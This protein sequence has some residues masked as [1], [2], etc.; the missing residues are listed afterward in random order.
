MLTAQRRH[1]PPCKRPMWDKGYTKCTCPV[2]IRGTLNRER[3]YGHLNSGPLGFARRGRLNN[4]RVRFGP[5]RTADPLPQQRKITR[6]LNP[7]GLI[8]RRELPRGQGEVFAPSS[9]SR[10]TRR[11][12]WF[13]VFHRPAS[14]RTETGTNRHRYR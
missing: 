10:G 9:V 13:A 7:S 14:Y 11:I 3:R 12:A 4:R 1:Q 2:M 6:R 5:C 8:G